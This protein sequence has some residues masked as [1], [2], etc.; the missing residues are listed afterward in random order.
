MSQS[1]IPLNVV[2]VNEPRIELNNERSWVV[3][4]GGQQVTYYA[5]PSTSFSNSQFNFICNP[6]SANTILDRAVFIEVPYTITFNVNTAI[7]PAPTDNLLQPGRDAF[8]AFPISSITNTLT[9]TING[10]P[11][12]IE[13]SQVIHALSRFHAP[14]NL[15][16]GWMSAQPSFEDN[17]QLYSDADGATNNPLGDY[18][19]SAGMSEIGRGAYHITVNSNT[20]TQAVITGILREQIFLPPFL[21]D[22]HQAGGLSNLTS[23][24]FN[25]ILNNNL[26]RIWSHSDITDVGGLS[27]IGSINVAFSQPSMYLGFITP[28]LSQPIPP[29]ITYPYFQISRYTTQTQSTLAPNDSAT[30]KSNIIQLDSIPRKL[31]I[32]MKQSDSQIYNNLHNQIS[33]PDV[34][35]QIN[36]VNITWNNQQGVLSGA[37]P[38]NL[39]DFSVQNGYNK[40]WTEWK[41]ITQRLSGATGVNTKKIGLEG[42]IICI[43]LSKDIG[44]NDSESE[45]ILGNYNLQVQ[46]TV[47]NTNQK[48][49]LT[50]DMYIIAVYD[51]TLVISNTS[52]MASIGVVTKE[53]VL[54]APPGNISFHELENIYGGDFFGRF[55]NFVGNV[56]SFLKKYKPISTISGIIPHPIAQGVSQTAKSLGYGHENHMDHGGVR[57]GGVIAGNYYNEDDRG[58]IL[59]GGRSL[60]KDEL[61]KRLKM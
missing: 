34:F 58:G 20:P 38:Q 30:Y 21:W 7:T 15:K 8:R 23:L 53:E 55:K 44:L 33:T 18:L 10:F 49:T 12:N 26:A 56:N 51:G 41:G 31:Y 29:K 36:S 57:A 40:S 3:I 25:W 48:T 16:N 13:L 47:T 24:T 28:R 14:L 61:R 11:T 32:Y 54:N 37:S 9:A 46:L 6:P 50:P 17:Y 42:S 1:A 35:L 52:A 22:G 19:D 39:Y 45:G 59:S 43:E 5:F 60:T 2:S 27:T 4:K